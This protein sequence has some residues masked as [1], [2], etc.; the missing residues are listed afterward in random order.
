MRRRQSGATTE[1]L[2][3]GSLSAQNGLHSPLVALYSEWE[4]EE[5]HEA[6]SRVLGFFKAFVHAS[7]DI[8]A[9]PHLDSNES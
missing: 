6:V 5:Q 1:V 2:E 3:K 9:E 4:A 8:P 7:A